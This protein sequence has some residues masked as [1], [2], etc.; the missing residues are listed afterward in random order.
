MPSS[1]P[2]PDCLKPPNG[3]CGRTE[4]F[5]FTDRT[6]E[7]MRAR[8]PQGA[9]PVA[10]PDR[11]R[12]PERRVVGEAHRLG[13]VR[14]R[15]HGRDRAEDLVAGDA[16]VVR[17]LDDRARVP[18]AGTVR[19]PAAERRLAVDER[20][21]RLAV[22]GGDERAH[23][24]PV[25]RGVAHADAVGRLHEPGQEL[26]VDV[27][28]DEDPRTGTAVLARVVE[29]RVGRRG[30]GAIEVGVGEDHVRGLA[31]ELERDA[32][33]R[34]RRSA[35]HLAADLRRAGEPDLGHVRVLHEPAA[36]DRA[37]ADE[38]VDDAFRDA[39]VEDELGQA[40][41]R[42]RRQLGG[43][44][45]DRVP[46]GERRPQFPARDV[47]RKV[48]GHDQPDD[49]ERLAERQIDAASNG[50]R[51]AMM[52]VDRTGIEVED[53]GHHRHLAAGAGNRLADVAGLDAGELLGVLLDERREPP[54]QPRAVARRH[55]APRRSRRARSA[56]R[57]VGLVDACLV[58]LGD[59]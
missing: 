16:V 4:E 42:E 40:E 18:E 31:A 58:E 37:L 50:D 7:S 32:L 23:L 36:D 20:G 30:C 48:P 49:A 24:R 3:V 5:E 44:E 34:A 57:L 46:A 21:D 43:L 9:R 51:L 25:A 59:R 2:N 39:G 8:D 19:H 22:R 41:R 55:T 15:D 45:H 11:S 52:L 26:V 27:P 35:H 33:D 56:H 28:L 29:H 14:E 38:H 54:Q 1:R 6:P 10:R 17:G 12:Q 13:L 53:L 47:E